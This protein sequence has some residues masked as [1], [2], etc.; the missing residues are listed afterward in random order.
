[1]SKDI[2]RTLQVILD[3]RR[4]IEPP[5]AARVGAGTRFFGVA[6]SFFVLL[7]FG[8]VGEAHTALRLHTTVWKLCVSAHRWSGNRWGPT[9]PWWE[10][11]RLTHI[12]HGVPRWG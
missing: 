12:G 11:M 10:K 5:I 4:K 1:M 3:V 6:V 7:K 9:D 2:P 8:A